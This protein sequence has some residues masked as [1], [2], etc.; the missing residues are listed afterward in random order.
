LESAAAQARLTPDKQVEQPQTEDEE[1]MSSLQHLPGQVAEKEMRPKVEERRTSTWVR[2]GELEVIFRVPPKKLTASYERENE[3]LCRNVM[4]T[5]VD[6]DCTLKAIEANSSVHC[7]SARPGD[8]ILLISGGLL[9]DGALSKC[10]A[11][12]NEVLPLTEHP[13]PIPPA[14]LRRLAH[15]IAREAISC[16][17]NIPEEVSP[18]GYD[19]LPTDDL[20]IQGSV[21]IAEVVESVTSKSTRTPSDDVATPEKVDAKVGRICSRSGNRHATANVLPRFEGWEAAKTVHCSMSYGDYGLLVS[22]DLPKLEMPSRPLRRSITD[23]FIC[24]FD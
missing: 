24:D 8:I 16:Q 10:A 1:A 22:L 20:P 17:N 21:V 2:V 6:L 23:D 19:S 9:A 3:R 15:R 14:M 11:I 7:A 18:A 5:D 13:S 12:C 4:D